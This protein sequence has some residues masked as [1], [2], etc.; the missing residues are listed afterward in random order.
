MADG[1]VLFAKAMFEITSGRR[2]DETINLI[3]FVN[4]VLKRF[5]ILYSLFL[6][7]DF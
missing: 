3:G 2:R 5:F 4:N 7:F 1:G 6:I